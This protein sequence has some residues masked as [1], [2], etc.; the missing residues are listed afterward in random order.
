MRGR[1]E[2]DILRSGFIDEIPLI[3]IGIDVTGK[4]LFWNKQAE[5][6]TGI[7]LNEAVALGLQTLLPVFTSKDQTHTDISTALHELRS[8]FSGKNSIDGKETV[9]LSRDGRVQYIK[10]SG[11][12]SDG[13]GSGGERILILSGVDQTDLCALREVVTEKAKYMRNT[14]KRL[15]ES[16]KVD[17]MTGLYNYHHLI[18][19]LTKDF[20]WA[21]ENDS[22]VS[23]AIINIGRYNSINSAYGTTN[24]DRFLR[25]LAKLVKSSVHEDFLVS[26]FAGSEIA[27]LMP[28]TD[29]KTAFKWARRVFLNVAEYDFGLAEGGLK[30]NLPARMALGGVPHCEDARTPEQLIGRVLD[31]LEEARTT[32]FPSVLICSPDALLKDDVLPDN[33]MKGEYPYTVEF[34]NALARAVKSKD[35]YTQE[36]ST[37]MSEYAVSIAEYMGLSK[38][39]L[40][41]V[42]LGSILHDVGKIG[43]DKSILLKPDVLTDAERE[44]IKQHP[45]IGAEI[46]RN[47]HPLKRV[48]PIVLHHHERYDGNGYLDG[49]GG[50]EIPMGAR[51]VSLADVFQ[52]LT[53]NRPYR[54]ALPNEDALSIIKE[55][56]GTFFDPAVVKAFFEV[57]TA[58]A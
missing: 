24:G 4:I 50:N 58:T 18:S 20:Y 11:Y 26:R 54:R 22:S 31:K 55:Y 36:H 35:N 57:H 41:D 52:A 16:S 1:Y 6:A 9:L 8:I 37:V 53:S 40:R 14:A 45:R 33:L 10:W 42:R 28:R 56:S 23:L 46:I 32:A 49:L 39:A 13:T 15:K 19:K 25:E 43:I 27:I 3:I 21:I 17:H 47:V 34:V 5:E 38:N 2:L 29:I 44:V 48:V 51:I 12:M 7:A 30:V